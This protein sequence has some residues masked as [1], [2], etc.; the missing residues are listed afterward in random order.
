M[1]RLLNNIGK[2]FEPRS[3][4]TMIVGP[5]QGPICFNILI[6]FLKDFFEKCDFEKNQQTTKKHEKYTECNDLMSLQVSGLLGTVAGVHGTLCG[7]VGSG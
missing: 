3:G 6:V 1:C 2:Q 7:S 4:Q 5:D